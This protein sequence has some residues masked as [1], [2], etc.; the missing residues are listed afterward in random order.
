M[1]YFLLRGKETMKQFRTTSITLLLTLLTG[2]SVPGFADDTE[3]Y[4][5]PDA[6]RP[7]ILFMLDHSGSMGELV[8]IVD[9][10][11]QETKKTR[12]AVLQEALLQMLD[13]IQDVNV[14]LGRFAWHKL[15]GI[16]KTNV[17]IQYR[18]AYI[19]EELEA[20]EDTGTKNYSQRIVDH[21][22]DAVENA[23]TGEMMLT[24]P[25]LGLA[26][27]G[28]QQCKI[29]DD[30]DNVGDGESNLTVISGYDSKTKE[31]LS[32]Q[33]AKGLQTKD[34]K[35]KFYTNGAKLGDGVTG[36]RFAG[37]NI[38]K[39]AIIN[40][41]NI[42]FTVQHNDPKESLTLLVHGEKVSNAKIFS[43]GQKVTRYNKENRT[44]SSVKWNLKQNVSKGET[45]GTA[46][47]LDADMNLI[48]QEIVNLPD[49][50]EGNAVVFFFERDANEGTKKIVVSSDPQNHRSKIAPDAE[51]LPKLEVTFGGEG[52]EEGCCQGPGKTI[53]GLRFEGVN[54]PRG[55]KIN[56]AYIDFTSVI[57][58]SVTDT[59]G[60]D[61]YTI[62]AQLPTSADKVGGFYPLPFSNEVND[63]SKREQTTEGIEWQVASW[64]EA[65]I[66][67]HE[68]YSTDDLS[69]IVQE[70]INSEKWCGGSSLAFFISSENEESVLRKAMSYDGANPNYAPKLTIE[71][72]DDGSSTGCINYNG[73]WPVQWKNDDAEQIM[74]ETTV[75]LE[76]E[77]LELGTVQNTQNT[78][79]RIVGLRFKRISI[80]PSDAGKIKNAHLILHANNT[81]NDAGTFLNIFGEKVFEYDPTFTSPSLGDKEI[82]SSRKSRR[83][84]KLVRWPQQGKLPIWEQGKTYR[85]VDI[86]DIVKEIISQKDTE[87]NEYYWKAG[88]SMVF[89][90]TGGSGSTGQRDI[91]SFE[92][93]TAPNK[94]KKGKEAFLQIEIEG[95]LSEEAEK[96]ENESGRQ[97]VRVREHLQGIVSQMTAPEPWD[98]WFTPLNDALYE[99]ALYYM[100]KD[101]DYG[102]TR[103]NDHLYLVSHPDT[104]DN[105]GNKHF[106]PPGCLLDSEP[107]D[108]SCAAEEIKETTSYISPVETGGCQTNHIVLLTDGI[109]TKNESG[110]GRKSKIRNLIDTPCDENV[111][112]IDSIGYLS[113]PDDVQKA[114]NNMK[115]G[116]ELADFLNDR[117]RVKALTGLNSNIKTHTIGFSLGYNTGDKEKD[118]DNKIAVEYLKR[119]A[120][121]KATGGGR[122]FYPAESSS[123][124]VSAF[125]AIVEDAQT[126]SAS[127]AAPG[128][129]VNRFN[130]LLHNDEVY[131]ALFKPFS[132]PCW[133]GNVK[134]FK[135]EGGKIQDRK[136]QSAIEEN[137]ISEDAYSYWNDKNDKN[138][139]PD[140]ATV[141]AG[142]AG[143]MLKDKEW[144]DR[145][146]F[147]S[148]EDALCLL[149]KND[150]NVVNLVQKYVTPD[151]LYDYHV[152]DLKKY[153]TPDNPDDPLGYE[154]LID[155]IKGR[156]VKNEIQDG[157]RE[158][159][160]PWSFKDPLHSSPQVIS[161]SSE[162]TK[163]IFGTNDGLIR[164]ID[165]KT[166]GEEWAFLP[167]ELLYK[168]PAL[169]ENNP[170]DPDDPLAPPPRIYGIDGT[171][172][173]WINDA[174]NDAVISKNDFVR[175][176]IGMRRGGRN[177]YALD[178]TN[179]P[180]KLLWVIK[181][182]KDGEDNEGKSNFIQLGQ[183]WSDPLP[184]LVDP[185]YCN[186]PDK[187]CPVLLFGGG[188]HCSQDEK[189]GGNTKF[190]P[191]GEL[192][193]LGYE[194]CAEE[195]SSE[196]KDGGGGNAIYMVHAE[197]GELL[198][199]ASNT[200]KS[201]LN[202]PKMIYPI[203]SKLALI[204]AGGGKWINRIYVGDVGGQIWRIDLLGKEKNGKDNTR[205]DRLAVFST[206]S[207]VDHMVPK[208]DRRR[209][210]YPPEWIK[211]GKANL[212]E[213]VVIGSGTRQNPL[214]TTVKNRLYVFRDKGEWNENGKLV[215]GAVTMEKLTIIEDASEESPDYF[216]EGNLGWYLDFLGKGE[217]NLGSPLVHEK[218]D[219]EKVVIFTTYIPS[220]PL[221]Q[222]DNVC[223]NEGRSSLYAVNLLTG[224]AGGIF[225]DPEARSIDLGEGIIADPSLLY[226]GEKAYGNG[227]PPNSSSPP[228][229]PP[230]PCNGGGGG[231]A[232][233]TG[234]RL[235]L[236]NSCIPFIKTFWKQS[237]D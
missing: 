2:L 75:H 189:E 93:K 72:A 225:D 152:A 232:L 18:V 62:K 155:W 165:A 135:I 103:H 218:Q 39:G 192:D 235:D 1:T 221:E 66:P 84:T 14:G 29:G 126:T 15:K 21:L 197:T 118:E 129:S 59:S 77:E 142:G 183:T 74:T 70:V 88:N 111:T 97:G 145:K 175:M 24:D 144:S 68:E 80:S 46:D 230:P 149:D 17:P 117:D 213:L 113:K 228:G 190:T 171:S 143:Q 76:S 226:L 157:N 194:A 81:N 184:A 112:E 177:I 105:S 223:F 95:A 65:N 233:L 237:Y 31:M 205:G 23:D 43:H 56:K 119:L 91:S 98:K 92:D 102:K 204:N 53:V 69:S 60:F 180:P 222:D 107:F 122:N 30:G 13:E 5:L 199:W 231:I 123:Q 202:L 150:E 4:F 141:T 132:A 186:E 159:T 78:T 148:C 160:R 174:G 173:F 87:T 116:I 8:T 96:V 90:I 203:P 147:T 224:G 164:M 182:G 12:M 200:A 198:W 49:W 7:N 161:Y 108:E 86:S 9:D 26:G 45:F 219:G 162:D 120:S 94:D 146:I 16:K 110:Q 67:E 40:Q 121:P 181:G 100:G 55:T 58:A 127:F 138:E 140:G 11:G 168:Q 36:I 61:T 158:N 176:Y 172:K 38:P 229:S 217:K 193:E 10:S 41:A 156:D 163:L 208:E 109:A 47:D 51:N 214:E 134:K 33:Q 136:G 151:N 167:K 89:F 27:C 37:V 139:K 50:E 236:L 234:T 128:I 101:V 170:S 25:E 178:V 73:F 34:T 196:S 220:N 35:Y 82:L 79:Q 44:S 52:G 211:V 195:Y 131:F 106:I 154:I 57:D 54:I 64:N 188:Y 179:S 19:D 32:A 216:E 185:T 166:G 206:D 153:I 3:I 22:N 130:R 20:K 210:F 201:N 227:N 83:Q 114:K 6:S 125:K 104:F 207:D 42:T 191:T 215:D 48:L 137:R 63:I 169:M 85:S 28:I 124:L 115:C 133:D 209:F 99:A 187:I 71:F 212:G